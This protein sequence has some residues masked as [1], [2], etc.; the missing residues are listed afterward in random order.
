MERVHAAD[1]ALARFRFYGLRQR[2]RRNLPALAGPADDRTL[3]IPD[4]AAATGS[5]S[6]IAHAFNET[7]RML[8]QRIGVFTA[9]PIAALDQLTLQTRIA[10]IGRMEGATSG[11]A[12]PDVKEGATRVGG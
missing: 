6:E 10:A 11:A 12:Q 4:P 3:G 2:R 8:S 1:C 7:Y 5:D 9:L